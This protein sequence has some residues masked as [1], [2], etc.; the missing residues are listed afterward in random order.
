MMSKAD[1]LNL[2]NLSSG[3]LH[4]M[5]HCAMIAAEQFEKDSKLFD[6]VDAPATLGGK[7]NCHRLRQQF[8]KQAEEARELQTACSDAIYSGIQ[9]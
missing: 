9:G 3:L 8:I 7:E 1:K 5:Q 6:H 2:E 4:T